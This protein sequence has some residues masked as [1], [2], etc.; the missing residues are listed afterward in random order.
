MKGK[1]PA[2]RTIEVEVVPK[3]IQICT[4]QWVGERDE[5]AFSIIGL[6]EDGYVYRFVHGKNGWMRY[7]DVLVGQYGVQ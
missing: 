7:P 6:G 1:N 4:G 3:I 5:M 2:K